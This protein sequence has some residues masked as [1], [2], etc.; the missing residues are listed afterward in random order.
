MKRPSEASNERCFG[1]FVAALIGLTLICARAGAAQNGDTDLIKQ[2]RDAIKAARYDIAITLFSEAIR[3]S[4]SDSNAWRG[5]CGAYSLLGDPDRAIADCNQTIKLAPT[6]PKSW[7]GRCMAY[8]KWGQYGLAIADCD[9]AIRIAPES[10]EAYQWRA[11]VYS[12]A[13]DYERAIAD[14]SKAIAL[15]PYGA[16]TFA[17]RGYLYLRIQ[18]PDKAMAD[19]DRALKMDPNNSDAYA[20][21]GGAWFAKGNYE[22]AWDDY[23]KAIEIDR[24]NAY[25]FA[26]RGL[27]AANLYNY[28]SA[29]ADF[30]EVLKIDANYPGVRNSRELAQE[31]KKNIWW[32]KIYVGLFGFGM[33]AMVYAAFRAY[34]SPT[35]FSNSIER[36]FRRTPDGMLIFHA[37][38][39]HRGCIVPDAERE[40]E[41]RVF[42]RHW[43][44]MGLLWPVSFMA[45]SFALGST[46]LF[47][48]PRP[49]GTSP[50]WLPIAY[51]CVTGGIV[52]SGLVAGLWLWRRAALHGLAKIEQKQKRPNSGEYFTDFIR[53]TP[54]AVR[55]ILLAADGYLFL[56]SATGLW[57][58]RYAFSPARIRNVSIMQWWLLASYVMGLVFFGSCLNLA[59]R[60]L[61]SDRRNVSKTM[62][63]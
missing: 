40:R 60:V 46:A 37:P 39:W 50:A 56:E 63:S 15:D 2:G 12:K 25:A 55:W 59:F 30:D 8:S 27:A 47:L 22:R 45:V 42:T 61:R 28:D 52:M 1:L 49:D 26:A 14:Y 13:A 31:H 38:P 51:A 36:R 35:A 16:R 11:H 24:G 3:L 54:L 21:R 10:A 58:S 9:Q 7:E 19:C 32:G 43:M 62:A 20:E 44:A 34:G 5:R 6:D 23:D 18:Q 4:P 48:F 57:R 33:L 41:L 17:E 53:D 29:I